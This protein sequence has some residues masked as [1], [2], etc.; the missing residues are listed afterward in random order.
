MIP[1]QRASLA[2]QLENA[3]N[4]RRWQNLQFSLIVLFILIMINTNTNQNDSNKL[5]TS[6]T[7]YNENYNA[8]K[9]SS[10]Y[11]R[12]LNN[13]TSVLVDSESKV[14]NA[15][16][17]YKGTFKTSN[18]SVKSPTSGNLFIQLKSF[19][20]KNIDNFEYIYGVIKLFGGSSSDLIVPIQGFSFPNMHYITLMSTKDV[21]DRV[22]L[23]VRSKSNQQKLNT[24]LHVQNNRDL[25]MKIKNEVNQS[26]KLNVI[27]DLNEIFHHP[28]DEISLIDSLVANGKN[29]FATKSDNNVLFNQ[30]HSI[31]PN[32][33]RRAQNVSTNMIDNYPFIKSSAALYDT[34]LNMYVINIDQ[35]QRYYDSKRKSNSSL[36]DNNFFNPDII[37]SVGSNMIPTKFK[38]FQQSIQYP[39]YAANCQFTILLNS[40]ITTVKNPSTFKVSKLD[41]IISSENCG[42]LFNVSTI[43]YDD[44]IKKIN[45]KTLNYSS[46]AMVI[47]LIQIALTVYQIRYSNNQAIAT[48]MSILSVCNQ[49]LIDAIICV[50]HLFMSA[51]LPKTYLVVI[52]GMKLFLF[53]IFE[54][55]LVINIY[56]AR[57]LGEN[58]HVSAIQA[59]RRTLATFHIRFY[60]V[61]FLIVIIISL[62][63]RYMWILVFIIYSYNIPQ[64]V[65]NVVRGTRNSL[66]IY[67]YGGMWFTRMFIPL[68]FFGCPYNFLIS[69][70]E[71][72]SFISSNV[73]LLFVIWGTLQVLILAL[74]DKFGPRFFLPRS[75]FPSSYN[76]YRPIPIKDLESSNQ[77]EC[78]ICYNII[79]A[80]NNDYMIAP[81]DHVFH[82]SCLQQWMN[83]KLECAICREKLPPLIEE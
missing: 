75:L 69:L 66:H 35:V 8:N 64:I 77:N 28:W 46:V 76:Y 17:I 1:I 2:G 79:E 19:P 13:I 20:V 58:D 6:S 27:R 53:C 37:D 45:S 51:S 23:K 73:C 32:Y 33:R 24:T 48:K 65:L 15:T 83:I 25:L 60:A 12:E 74:Q 10:L 71:S 62:L 47:C 18:S 59:L 54:T 72:K 34:G 63:H 36:Y 49:S 57:N 4:Q 52:F 26:G 14:K 44:E 11:L 7:F 43:S 29:I 22:F 70:V 41:G 39:S 5:S 40:K 30:S 31:S 38:Y 21:T 56:Q 82:K 80:H 81:C 9:L 78:V 61:L 67:Y 55:K 50:S 3:F 42:L 16:G 68:Y